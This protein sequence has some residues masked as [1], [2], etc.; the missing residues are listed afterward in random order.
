MKTNNN[1]KIN[2]INKITFSMKT[3]AIIIIV[4]SKLIQF[5]YAQNVVI[6]ESPGL[7]PLNNQVFYFNYPYIY[8]G[9]TGTSINK[10]NINDFSDVTSNI[11]TYTYSS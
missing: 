9:G 8:H 10:Y 4:F 3:I 6:T 7:L 5:S 2:K 1:L 11:T